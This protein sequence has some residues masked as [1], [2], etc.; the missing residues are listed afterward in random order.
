MAKAGAPHR[1][2]G[3]SLTLG[4][5]R[6]AKG[7]DMAPVPFP[8][9]NAGHPKAGLWLLRILCAVALCPKGMKDWAALPRSPSRKQR[10]WRCQFRA[11]LAS[12]GQKPLS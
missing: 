10:R 8:P 4:S 2:K 11:E 12:S 5:K 3:S 9:R 1:I 7:V 6:R